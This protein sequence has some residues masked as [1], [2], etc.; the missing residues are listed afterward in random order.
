MLRR[1]RSWV[2]Q[3]ILRAGDGGALPAVRFRGIVAQALDPWIALAVALTRPDGVLIGAGFGV[4]GVFGLD[5]TQLR[6]YV[7]HAAGAAG[8]ALL[9]FLGRYLYFGL[10]LPLPLYV[11]SNGG[12]LSERLAPNI[13]FLR[14][15]ELAV[16][17]ALLAI[18]LI[19]D[20]GRRWRY[21]LAFLP[22]GL[23]LAVLSLA[24]QSQNFADRFQTPVTT[25]LLVALA[26]FLREQFK[27]AHRL[28]KVGLA[29]IIVVLSPAG[30]YGTY[31]WAM[32]VVHSGDY[33]N[34]LA[35]GLRAIT[36]PGTT[37]ALT[38]AGRLPFWL[39]DAKVYD[40]V[41]LNTPETAVRPVTRRFL[42]DLEP[43]LIFIH[44]AGT[45]VW[46]SHEGDFFE[47]SARE[48]A[49]RLET[50]ERRLRLPEDSHA[51]MAADTTQAY[52]AGAG[53]EYRIFVVRYSGGFQHLYAVRREGKIAPD[54]FRDVLS[55]SFAR[56]GYLSYMEQ[57]TLRGEG[58]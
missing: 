2:L 46:G 37:I 25:A 4:V 54:A 34:N 49:E 35:P 8:V 52:L 50:A 31:Q 48:L 29:A 44:S 41:G 17:F 11:K 12:S 13:L 43:D 19:P 53:N 26:I 15:H 28:A 18:P 33:V 10:P 5:R 16:L 40:L 45:V 57:R 32:R 42:S 27:G 9:Y 21:V 47:V 24:H 39:E 23:F 56:R 1:P 20:R 6:T 30:G 55:R 22:V 38:E 3:R 7:K 58:R 36:P 14:S 51:T